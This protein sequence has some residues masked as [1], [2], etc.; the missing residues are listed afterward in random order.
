MEIEEGTIFQISLF[1]MLLVQMKKFKF[2]LD[3]YS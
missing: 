2:I 1:R 3:I